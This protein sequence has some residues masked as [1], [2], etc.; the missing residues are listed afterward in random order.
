M[1]VAGA[2]A[3][4]AKHADFFSIEEQVDGRSFFVTTFDDDTLCAH[5]NDSSRCFFYFLG[6]GQFHSGELLGFRKVR[7]HNLRQWDELG[8][9]RLNRVLSQQQVAR[10]CDHHRVDHEILQVITADLRSDG[11]DQRSIGEHPGLQLVCTDVLH[12][13]IDLGGHQI[14]AQFKNCTDFDSVLG[15]DRSDHRSSV[16]PEGGERLEIGL[17]S[18]TG[19]GI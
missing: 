19:T 4:R 11:L 14:N 18:S 16:D 3:G 13:R 10:F 1:S 12:D 9:K 6:P 2:Y 17:Y 15:S 5:R 7:S 8:A